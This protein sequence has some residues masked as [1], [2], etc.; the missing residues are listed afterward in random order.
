MP[1]IKKVKEEKELIAEDTVIKTRE[2]MVDELGEEEVAKIEE[3]AE[4]IENKQELPSKEEKIDNSIITVIGKGNKI[5]R[6]YTLEMH[7]KEYKKLAE[8][9]AKKKGLN[10]K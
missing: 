3:E 10:I 1:K 2:E 9:F 7:G 4:I 6:T 5:I 8:E